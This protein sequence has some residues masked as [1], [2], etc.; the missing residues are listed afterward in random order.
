M[1]EAENQG[2]GVEGRETRH[3]LIG[4]LCSVTAFAPAPRHHLTSLDAS[5][6]Y[7]L[8]IPGGEHHACWYTKHLCLF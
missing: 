3:L 5:S 6:S 4:N 1:R 7:F 2:A 8:S